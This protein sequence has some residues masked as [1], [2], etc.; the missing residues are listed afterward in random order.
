MASAYRR[1][2]GCPYSSPWI[3]SYGIC[4][5][6]FLAWKRNRSF[7]RVSMKPSVLLAR[8]EMVLPTYWTRS[9]RLPAREG[10]SARVRITVFQAVCGF[11]TDLAER[12]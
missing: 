1:P 3:L 10:F 7:W 6:N 2:T 11:S 12:G 8:T 5:V 9:P 4:T